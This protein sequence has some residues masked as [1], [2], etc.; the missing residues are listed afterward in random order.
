MFDVLRGLE[1]LKDFDWSK[2][3]LLLT[4]GAV[5]LCFIAL[6]AA[7]YAAQV[8]FGPMMRVGAFLIAYS[9]DKPSAIHRGMAHGL[10]ISIW[11]ALVGLLLVLV[12]R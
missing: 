3:Y 2:V 6:A 10:R 9:P 5:A 7:T 8:V 11:A 12:T 1:V 4:V